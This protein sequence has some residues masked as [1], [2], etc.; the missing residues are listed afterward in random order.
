M[1]KKKTGLNSTLF[2]GINPYGQSGQATGTQ[3]EDGGLLE[4]PLNAISFDPNQPRY[5]IPTQLVEPFMQGSMT[6]QEVLQEWL[7]LANETAVSK[8]RQLADTIE[9]HGLIQPI[10]VRQIAPRPELPDI[11]YVLIAGERRF[12]AHVLLQSQRRVIQIAQTDQ[13]VSTVKAIL[14]EE[15]VS[16]RAYQIIENLVR[17]DINAIDKARGLWALRYELSGI[18]ADFQTRGY[19]QVNHG[20]PKAKLV[21]WDAVSDA[22]GISKRYRI[23]VTAVLT[24]PKEAQNL[25]SQ[26]DLP[27]RVLRPVVQKLKGYPDA[28]VQAVQQLIAWKED[29]ND[30]GEDGSITKA[31]EDLVARLLRRL[32]PSQQKPQTD[33]TSVTKRTTKI[34]SKMKSALKAVEKVSEGE[35]NELAVTLNDAHLADLKTL[36]EKIDTILMQVNALESE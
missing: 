9:Q 2:S 24:L 8:L 16:V 15:G 4:I 20:S 28:Q 5:F 22:L 18:E 13:P 26:Y 35:V 34:M 12:W 36:R 21:S 19:D 14:A 3:A 30:E 33:T 31:V 6:H 29:G 17:D 32:E 27:E 1:A 25:V 11:K 23:Y 10:I 7:Q